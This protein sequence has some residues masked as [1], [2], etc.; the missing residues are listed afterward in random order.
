LGTARVAVLGPVRGARLFL[1]GVLGNAPSFFLL[2]PLPRVITGDRPW[3]N[4]E[5]SLGKG[6]K[7]GT[8]TALS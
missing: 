3:Q 2:L 1:E 7:Q 6:K 5:R 8:I 4:Y